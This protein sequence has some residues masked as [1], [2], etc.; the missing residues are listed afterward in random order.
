MVH[1]SVDLRCCGFS[2]WNLLHF[3][4]NLLI[5]LK[6]LQQINIMSMNHDWL[7]AS[8]EQIFHFDFN[9]KTEMN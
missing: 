6:E 3:H 1:G 5:I 8:M 7:I 9:R 4:F 2:N